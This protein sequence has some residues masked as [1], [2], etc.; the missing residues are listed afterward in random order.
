MKLDKRQARWLEIENQVQ[1]VAEC[2]VVAGDPA[3]TE[4]RLLE[5]L[6][7][8]EWADG[9]EGFRKRG[10]KR[11]GR[12]RLWRARPRLTAGRHHYQSPR[13]RDFLR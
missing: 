8:L 9:Q 13:E 5:E 6:D 4:A 3:V 11:N 1:E 10:R 7:E 12:V 2:K